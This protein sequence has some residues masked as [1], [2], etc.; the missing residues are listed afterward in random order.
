MK[1]A[2]AKDQV[3]ITF[4][5]SVFII[6]YSEGQFV[7]DLSVLLISYA[8]GEDLPLLF[9]ISYAVGSSITDLT[10]RFPFCYTEGFLPPIYAFFLT[11][12]AEK[13][14]VTD[15]QDREADWRQHYNESSGNSLWEC[16][17]RGND[18]SSS[19]LAEFGN[20]GV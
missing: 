6:C 14:F 4:N 11:T 3:V 20:S 18:S 9:P 1:T 2:W 10:F 7:I 5:S 12:Y 17:G 8:E 15:F 16:E 19:L 13:S